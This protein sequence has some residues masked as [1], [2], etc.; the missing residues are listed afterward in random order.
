MSENEY[1]KAVETLNLWANAYYTKD[2][3]LATDAEYD[4]LYH[5]ILEFERDN[6][7][8]IS[9]E[10][11]SSRVGDKVLDA[12]EKNAHIEQMWSMED[13]FS[14]DE[15][16][17]WLERNNKNGLEMHVLPKFDGVSLNL[18]YENGKLAV[19]TTRGDGK[20]GENV[21]HNALAISSVLP[22][23]AYKG[24]IEIRGEVV[25]TKSDFEK[26]NA[27]LIAKGAKPLA[28]PRNAAAGSLRQLDSAVTRSRRLR[29]YPWGL[30]FNELGLKK[31]SEQMSFI[32]EL[33]FL[34]D[35][36]SVLC[37]SFDEIKT[38]YNEL[39]AQR[40]SKEMLL[41]GM[42]IRVNEL[43]IAENMGYT[44]KFPRFMVAFKFPPLELST[45][46]KDV[47][48]QVGR[49]GAL[50]PVGV[51]EPVNIEGAMVGFATLHNADEI[52]R[53]GLK[54]GDIIS[55]V[56]SGD[57]IPKITGVF[58]SRRDGSEQEI[59]TPT[60]CP[61]CN[62]ELFSDGAILKCQNLG[63]KERVLNSLIYFASKK[64]MNIDGL[65]SAIIT[66]LY[67]N[68]RLGDLMDIYKLDE[69]SFAG[70]E[71][72]GAKKIS[73]ILTSINESKTPPLERF[74]TALG[75]ELIGEVAAKKIAQN[76]PTSWLELGFDE[77]ISL[78]GFGENM[79]QSYLEFQRVNKQKVLE[80]LS[81]IKPILPQK[82]D[83]SKAVLAG[84]SVVITGTL[85]SPREQIK[86]RLEA[87]GARVSGS[88][89]AKTDFLLAG[90]NAGSKLEKANELGVKIVD[91]LWLE[92]LENAKS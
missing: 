56:R 21:T 75:C 54:K 39:L 61:C 44:V 42:V 1:L 50:T 81:V 34:K 37:S 7:F 33:G 73:N 12:F 53:L 47:L 49:T 10:S 76:Y 13:I 8:L 55:I 71:G 78:D 69:S 57:V 36:F 32:R 5:K 9:P 31:H 63:C 14:L 40:T 41:D 6:P 45:K 4:E 90:Q 29:F 74:I 11:P 19:A 20:I 88:V 17:A 89:S 15:L 85:K 82:I 60:L 27:E 68:G 83:T 92:S 38:A 62:S 86:A 26:I 64:C 28:N 58:S 84:A 87:L 43:E 24:K 22:K 23:I 67:E 79:A 3:P 80:L 51:L 91:E 65:G 18:L 70:L 35:D 52:S 46:L 77:L 30:G 25:I 66:T 72:F 48:W 2:E 59:K 16:G